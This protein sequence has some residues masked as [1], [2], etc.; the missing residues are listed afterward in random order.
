M[1][2]F[3]LFAGALHINLNE[4]SKQKWV[5]LSLATVGVLT[6]TFIIGG[7]SWVILNALELNIVRK[8]TV[9]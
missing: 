5:I 2:S 7:M 8:Q 9:F 6:S 4:L 1:L 3:L